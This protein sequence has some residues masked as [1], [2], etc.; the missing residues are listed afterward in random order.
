MTFVYEK[1][2][3]WM[4]RCGIASTETT[5]AFYCLCDKKNYT[6]DRCCIYLFN[7]KVDVDRYENKN[8]IEI[9][10]GT[11]LTLKEEDGNLETYNIDKHTDIVG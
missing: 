6:C 1:G 5:Q 2:R 4:Y 7:E 3:W 10:S 8:T 11:F 9:V